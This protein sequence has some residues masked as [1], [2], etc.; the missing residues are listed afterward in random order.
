LKEFEKIADIAECKDN[1]PTLRE[2][3]YILNPF[4]QGEGG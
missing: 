3:S 4:P 1:L 2:A